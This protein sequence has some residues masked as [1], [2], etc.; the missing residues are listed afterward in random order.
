MRHN[1]GKKKE[2]I[3]YIDDGRTIADMSG[4]PGPEL[5]N[6]NPARP[7]PK[8]KDVWN[9]CWNAVRMML[10]PTLALAG[11]LGIIYLIVYVI[12]KLAY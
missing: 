4:V 2:K 7:A 11:G 10:L 9:T 12:F 3:I 5:G 6:K 1:M 8:A